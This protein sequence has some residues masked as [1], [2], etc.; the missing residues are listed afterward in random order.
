MKT[1]LAPLNSPILDSLEN[2]GALNG[3]ALCEVKPF[4]DWKDSKWQHKIFTMRL[5]NAGEGLEVLESLTDIPQDAKPQ[6][7][8]FQL[9]SRSIFMIDGAT[10]VSSAE[11]YKFNLINKLN[12]DQKDYLLH[13][14]NNAEQAVLDRLDI[15]Y[16]SLQQKQLR[17]LNGQMVCDN[18]GAIHSS[19]Q[20]D[21]KKLIY[22]VSEMICN[23]CISLINANI[24]D[25]EE[26]VMQEKSK[27]KEPVVAEEIPRKAHVC[28]QCGKEFDTFEELD[29]HLPE[30]IK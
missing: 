30:C 6:A 14:F 13:W 12:Y 20:G 1:P 7:T 10:P 25:F 24:Y 17:Q 21:A 2:L 9:L 26:D 4:R 8:K 5:C 3:T 23:S 19:L 27:V 15:V 29:N 18:C 16:G 11:L 22:S 28:M